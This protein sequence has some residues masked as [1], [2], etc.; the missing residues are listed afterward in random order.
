MLFDIVKVQFQDD[1]ILKKEVPFA[2]RFIFMK[3]RDTCIIATN[4][5][6]VYYKWK[7]VLATKCILNTFHRDF[8]VVRMIGKGSFAKVL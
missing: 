7:E 6:E 8:Q 4:K 5:Q 3:N 2:Y 1:H